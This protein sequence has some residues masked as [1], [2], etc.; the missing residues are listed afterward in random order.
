EIRDLQPGWI[1]YGWG[2]CW[3]RQYFG[4]SVKDIQCN[5]GTFG[6]PKPGVR[7]QCFYERDGH[8]DTFQMKHF[9]WT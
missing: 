4:S 5:N 2:D 1:Y 6:D 7:K 9:H 8:T 3:N